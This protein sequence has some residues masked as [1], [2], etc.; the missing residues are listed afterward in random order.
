MEVDNKINEQIPLSKKGET[1][2]ITIDP[3]NY[4]FELWV[5]GVFRIKRIMLDA[6]RA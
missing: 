4:S 2:N 1:V 5:D 3:R 6:F